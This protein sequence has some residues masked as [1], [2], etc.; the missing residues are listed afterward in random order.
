MHSY[1][2]AYI[3]LY[4]YLYTYLY[5]YMYIYIYM[6]IYIYIYNICIYIYIYIYIHIHTYIHTYIYMISDIKDVYVGYTTL[7]IK[8]MLKF[9]KKKCVQIDGEHYNRRLY[10]IIR[11]NGGLINWSVEVLEEC[12]FDFKAEVLQKKREWCEKTPNDMNMIRYIYMCVCIYISIYTC[13]FKYT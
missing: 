10:Q 2:Y 13:I 4:I 12:Y 11:A 3:C 6:H 8:N 9:H 1:L 5:I 7:D